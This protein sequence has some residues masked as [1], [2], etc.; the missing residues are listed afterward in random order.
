ML[1][2]ADFKPPSTVPSPA[3]RGG[4]AECS[5]AFSQHLGGQP[6]RWP[7]AAQGPTPVLP[8]S[9]LALAEG[10]EDLPRV[11]CEPPL[12]RSPLSL[13]T[14]R[15]RKSELGAHPR[16][17]GRLIQTLKRKSA[18]F[19]F[20]NKM[21]KSQLPNSLG[22]GAAVRT[23]LEPP[24]PPD[25]PRPPPTRAPQ[26]RPSKESRSMRP[27]RN[28]A[29]ANLPLPSRD[30]CQQ[31]GSGLGER[32]RYKAINFQ[33][34]LSPHPK[35]WCHMSTLFTKVASTG[36][37][38]HPPAHPM[39]P[40]GWSLLG[41]WMPSHRYPR[42]RLCETKAPLNIHLGGPTPSPQSQARPPLLSGTGR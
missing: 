10:L 39:C 21:P 32:P 36:V 4:P 16:D 11:W 35:P 15:P 38:A 34:Y 26:P 23:R 31:T 8:A 12:S 42:S 33:Q 25:L 13:G 7:V 37:P 2:P 1:A 27:H 22:W 30:L 9:C 3:P 17:L 29:G 6:H 41:P 20:S 24:S 18:Q 19:C 5:Q 14:A 28:P 40:W